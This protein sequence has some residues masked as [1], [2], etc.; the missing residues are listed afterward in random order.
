M[1]SGILL[2]FLLSLFFFP[3][4]LT[5]HAQDPTRFEPGFE[6]AACFEDV[7]ETYR[8][9]YVTVPEW[10][11]LPEGNT[12][13]LAVVVVPALTDT[14]ASDPVVMAQG[15]PGGSTIEVFAPVASEGELDFIRQTRDIILIEQRGTR[16][17]E[18]YL[19]CTETQAFEFESLA[20]T[21]DDTEYAVARLG[22]LAECH[23]RLEAE[24]I[25]LNAFNSIENAADVPLVLDALGYEGKFNYYGVSYGTM[26]AQHLMRDYRERLRSVIIDAVVPLETN[27][28]LQS[29]FNATASIKFLFEACQADEQCAEAF[30][31]LEDTFFNLVDDWNMVPAEFT[32]EVDNQIY[33]VT[34]TGDD[35]LEFLR[36]SLY[37]TDLLPLLPQLIEALQ[38]DNFL[39]VEVLLPILLTST[40]AD[41]M[42]ASVICS[43][44][45][46]FDIEDYRLDD[47]YPGLINDLTYMIQAC[48]LWDVDILDNIVN[49]PV[50]SDV[51]VLLLSGDFD[52]ITP[53]RFAQEV[54][55]SLSNSYSFSFPNVGHGVIA[56][57]DCAN[58][59]MSQFL[60]HPEAEPD[61]TCISDL[62][63]SFLIEPVFDTQVSHEVAG[64]AFSLPREFREVNDY[65]FASFPLIVA[66]YRVEASSR[67]AVFAQFNGEIKGIRHS[68][69]PWEIYAIDLNDAPGWVAIQI[70]ENEA[71]VIAIFSDDP[72]ALNEET[73]FETF[74][75][76]LRSVQVD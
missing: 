44:D 65:A 17:S 2:I 59:I 52:P 60:A 34:M 73:L 67:D 6:E 38:Q 26:V 32:I 47:V 41:G 64:I 19:F 48:A 46:D 37:S 61:S 9:G 27:F 35:L 1:R 76:L 31:L 30:P 68:E 25:N 40:H 66:F 55:V 24:G 22:A 8:C 29:D 23:D 20:M 28:L 72:S 49:Q 5:A 74:M 70:M 33:E 12:L 57:S 43:E 71:I 3:F 75:P 11:S 58:T 39:W 14:P 21:L 10:H 45:G 4:S 56:S 62:K 54:A 53:A 69:V 15:G 51:P 63:I 7:P 42:Y 50:A 13:R 18:P 36:Q 16:F